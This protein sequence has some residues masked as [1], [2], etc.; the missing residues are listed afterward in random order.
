M[1]PKSQQLR[2]VALALGI[3]AVWWILW[4]TIDSG[5][6]AAPKGAPGTGAE[7]SAPIEDDAAS[8]GGPADLVR[9]PR[10]PIDSSLPS[11][12]EVVEPPPGPS[13]RLLGSITYESQQSTIRVASLRLVD[14]GWEARIE[15]ADETGQFLFEDLH[16][17]SWEL[18]VEAPGYREIRRSIELTLE[19]PDHRLDLVMTPGDIV[20]VKLLGQPSLHL[21]GIPWRVRSGDASA[22]LEPIATLEEPAGWIPSDSD[23]RG[24]GVGVFVERTHR[25]PPGS[26]P[27]A[28]EEEEESPRLRVRFPDGSTV[29]DLA[30]PYVGAFVLSKP[31]PFYASLVLGE[32]AIQTRVV[33]PGAHEVTFEIPRDLVEKLPGEVRLRVVDGDT[34]APPVWVNINLGQRLA[35]RRGTRREPNGEVVFEE[36]LPGSVN[37]TILAEGREV[38]AERVLVE[39]G[40]VTDLGVYRLQPF[41]LIR[42]KVVDDAG[43]PARVQFNVFPFDRYASTRETLG[44]RFFRSNADGRLEIDSV[45]R[46]RYLIVANEGG[47]VSIPAL[48]DTTSGTPADLEIRV[49]KGTPVAVRLRA[50]PLPA[51]RLEIRTRSGLPVAERKC[52]D[53]DPMRFTLV[54]GSYSVELWDGET[55][56]ASETLAVGAEPVRIYFPR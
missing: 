23:A 38:V 50:D 33:P 35:G 54:P 19:Q 10:E 29:D 25:R 27:E 40:G 43:E 46:G 6:P 18:L 49:S 36:V 21:T 13:L 39:P 15:H 34:D 53:R 48:A 12:P 41:S 26:G 22:R 4:R 45:G 9:E 24:A 16:P 56:L 28:I 2:I 51:A 42:A 31:L 17:G 1:R 5:G 20:K 7:V 3:V 47:W 8:P 11:E 32:F 14:S 30:P 55:W 37:L 44:K 52:R